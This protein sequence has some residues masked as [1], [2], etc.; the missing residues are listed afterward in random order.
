MVTNPSREKIIAQLDKLVAP[1]P[2]EVVTYLKYWTLSGWQESLLSDWQILIL[3]LLLDKN[4][5]INEATPTRKAQRLQIITTQTPGNTPYGVYAF[6]IRNDGDDIGEVDGQPLKPDAIITAAA[7]D[8]NFLISTSYD[9][10]GQTFQISFIVDVEIPASTEAEAK[11]T[12]TPFGSTNVNPDNP[13]STFDK[14]FDGDVQTFFDVDDGTRNTA[15]CGLDF[16][17]VKSIRKIRFVPRESLASRMFGGKFESSLDGTSYTLI[18]TI[19][20][21]QEGWNELS[22][23]V[24][25]ARYVRYVAPMNSYGNVAEIEFY[26]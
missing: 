8:G 25:S 14:V 5:N 10:K 13:T 24:A 12:G 15:V 23:D 21:A 7:T 17:S 26:S 22:V 16:G 3:R 6:S 9:P 4:R 11:L 1:L 20:T 18:Q 19:D 2:D